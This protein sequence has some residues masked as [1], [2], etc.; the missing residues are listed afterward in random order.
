MKH[1]TILIFLWAICFSC[2]SEK[3]ADHDDQTVP[4]LDETSKPVSSSENTSSVDFIATGN[5]PGWTLYVD[6]DEMLRFSAMTGDSI[7]VPVPEPEII[8]KEEKYTAETQAGSIQISITEEPC[9]DDMSGEDFSHTVLVITN[10]KEYLGC[11][12]YLTKNEMAYE[13][14][15]VLIN[16]NGKSLAR[17]KT[18]AMP[19]LEIKGDE[20]VVVGSTGCNQL[21]AQIKVEGDRIRIENITTTRMACR[22]SP[23]KE[24][25]QAI[26][27]INT[28]RVRADQLILMDEEDEL[29][30]FEKIQ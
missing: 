2:S 13:G 9:K 3:K 24:F 22:D 21:N 12:N 25:L 14:Q 10:E 23:E 18:Q 28:Y 5:E 19:M 4:R 27:N 17:S 15:W 1:L 6:F 16:L 20:S 11:G 8:G 29:L 26:N 7:E 30:V